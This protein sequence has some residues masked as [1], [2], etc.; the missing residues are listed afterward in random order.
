[1]PQHNYVTASE[2]PRFFVAP[3]HDIL[4]DLE[5]TP[6]LNQPH[7]RRLQQRE[8]RKKM[9]YAAY[10]RISS[11]DQVGNFSMD[12]QERAIQTWVAGQGGLLV[13][14]YKDEAKSGRT[15]DR[16]AFQQMRKDAR[17]GKFDALVVHKFF[18]EAGSAPVPQPA[19]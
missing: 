4:D 16:P 2:G 1:M 5:P 6:A 13:S 7:E 15:A 10:I 9:R 14:I 11:E 8:K 19:H 12:A 17:Q 18:P 3:R